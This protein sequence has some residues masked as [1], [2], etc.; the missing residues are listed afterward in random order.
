MGL[1]VLQISQNY[2]VRGGSDVMFFQNIELLEKHG[3]QVIPLAAR[4]GGDLAGQ[5]NR[6]FPVA[7]NFEHPGPLDLARFI[8]SVPARKAI[9]KIIREH[10]PQIAHLHIYYGKLTAS[11]LAPLKKAGIPIVQTLHEYK[12]ICPVYR[13]VSNETICQACEGRYFWRALPGRCNK[14]SL[15]RTALSVLE[16]YA[17]HRLGAVD[18]IDAFI[19]V[20]DALREKHITCGIPAHKIVT[21]RNWVDASAAVPAN[22]QGRYLLYFG[23]IE[24]LKGVFT[25]LE[26]MA[27]LPHIPLLLVGDGEA[28][29]AVVDYIHRKGWTHVQCPGFKTG[30]ELQ[31]LIR[32]SIGTLVP[33][34]WHEPFPTSILESF[35]HARPVIGSAIGGI[36][37][38]IADGRD[39][40]LFPPGD[41]PALR[42][43]ILRLYENPSQAIEM[44]RN[45]RQKV[46][47]VFSE[48]RYLKELLAVY[49]KVLSGK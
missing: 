15:A 12:L 41:V 32:H 31:D 29:Q 47:T 35:A 23:R 1:S 40:L 34:E 5:W 38:M 9:E 8:Y 43:K 24:R 18:K 7:S 42:Q 13:L 33:S 39:G 2:H 20:S 48:K 25:L 17:S 14:K 22:K 27:G 37:E 30:D 49:E 44:G 19:A 28:R 10:K 26:A 6:Y 3:H 4:G 21:I 16:S 11:I 46:E 45:G 36:P